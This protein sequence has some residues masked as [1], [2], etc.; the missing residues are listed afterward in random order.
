[1][2][3]IQN[4][5]QNFFDDKKLDPTKITDEKGINRNNV[6]AATD[7]KTGKDQ[8]YEVDKINQSD[9]F[10]NA[11]GVENKRSD[12]VQ[13]GIKNNTPDGVST[14][15]DKEARSAGDENVRMVQR[16]MGYKGVVQNTDA[17]VTYTRNQSDLNLIEFGTERFNGVGDVQ[18]LMTV[19]YKGQ[20][21][22]Q[23]E[24]LFPGQN[25]VVD[26]TQTVDQSAKKTKGTV[27]YNVSTVIA[28]EMTGIGDANRI[29]LGKDPYTGESLSPGARVVELG[30]TMLLLN[31]GKLLKTGNQFFKLGVSTSALNATDKTIDYTSKAESIRQGLKKLSNE[32]K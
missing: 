6:V 22:A 25:K 7:G 8:Y 11:L 13:K 24:D 30:K 15:A 28:V 4:S 1:V 14:A 16:E 19:T 27:L 3:G 26:I 10:A 31:S 32:K 18:P 21:L 5:S 20:T 29:I 12:Q 17:T 9:N 2:R 23:N